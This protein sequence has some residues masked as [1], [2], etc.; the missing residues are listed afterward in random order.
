M[1]DGVGSFNWSQA[2]QEH[3]RKFGIS[4]R[5][6]NPIPFQSKI[7]NR[8]SW[9]SFRRILRLLKKI[10]KRNHRKTVQIDRHIAF[11]GGLNI[12]QVHSEELMEKN[13]W[14][15]TGVRVT[16]AGVSLLRISF[17]QAW[18]NSKFSFTPARLNSYR[19]IVRLN[20]SA[21]WRYLI[22]RDL[23]SRFRQAKTRILITN[24]YFVP[25]RSVLRSLIRAARRGIFVGLCLPAN[26]DV[27]LVQWASRSL[28]SRLLK[29]G[30]HIYEFQKQT[31]HAKTLVIDDWATVGSHNLNHRSLLHDLEAEVVLEDKASLTSLIHDWDQDVKQ[32]HSISMATLGKQGLLFR[33]L[34][35]MAYW[36]RYWL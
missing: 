25:R 1:V 36:F 13:V 19:K 22:L 6:F 27:R 23:N 18:R 29:A 10:N 32:S 30:V 7:A 11:L 5:I 34:A 8:F 15:D 17:F 35:R 4:I 26:N 16:G 14:R 3:G 31:L 2:L 24:P 9:K 12:S 20:S 21:R 28:Y 33:V